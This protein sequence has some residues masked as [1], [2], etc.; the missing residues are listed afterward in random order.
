MR[1]QL[2]GLPAGPQTFNHRCPAGNYLDDREVFPH[3]ISI[4]ATL[5]GE[6]NSLHLSVETELESHLA[7]DRCGD[8]FTRQHHC[9]ADYYYT[10]GEPRIADGDELQ[11]TVP[12]DALELDISQEI[13]DLVLLSLPSPSLCREDCRGICS[14]C[15]KNL[16]THK[17]QCQPDSFDPRWE[18]LKKYKEKKPNVP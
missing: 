8:P 7:C 14:Q 12:K 2:S 17:C 9:R 18:A 16:N 13:R 1:I 15:G 11:C 3:D 5:E 6:G 4:R 10:F